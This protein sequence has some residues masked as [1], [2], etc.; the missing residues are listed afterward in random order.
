M[1]LNTRHERE[2]RDGEFEGR[3]DREPLCLEGIHRYFNRNGLV[4]ST[5]VWAWNVLR[6]GAMAVMKVQSSSYLFAGG[7]ER[8]RVCH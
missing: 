6:E 5:R 7:M 8:Q 3:R 2:M 1:I 4:T